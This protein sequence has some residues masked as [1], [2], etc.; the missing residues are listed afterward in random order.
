MTISSPSK[1]RK[2]L[3]LL[4][5]ILVALG[6]SACGSRS[7]MQASSWP[8]VSVADGTAYVAF[9][10]FVHAVDL[11]TG[12][13]IWTFPT[14]ADR[15]TTFYAPPA[16]SS[17]GETLVVGSYN[18]IIYA[19]NAGAPS[20]T[21]LWTFE[22]PEDRII[23]GPLIVED[24]VLVPTASGR[25]FAL[26]LEDGQPVWSEP[27]Q[28]EHA[29]WSAPIVQDDRVYV[30]GLDHFVY[31]ISLEDGRVNWKT[32]LGS[33]ISDS[34]T[35]TDG[36]LIS[37]N[38]AGT[39]AALDTQSG[40]VEWEFQADDSIWGSPAVHEGIAYFGDV[41]G[42]AHAIEVETGDELWRHVLSGPASASP[43]IFEDRVYFVTETGRMDALLLESGESAWPAS[44]EMVGRLLADPLL[45]PDGILVPAMESECL[46]YVV[47]PE[48]GAVRC[49][50]SAE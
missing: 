15:N 21:P 33:A 4:A 38:F 18:Q 35:L 27:F 19:L 9:G 11:E 25:L 28:A 5:L 8:G 3:I 10:Q 44:A 49:L 23:G 48:T 24:R 22:E 12:R 31:S 26:S 41:T 36:L 13:A 14:E 16:L 6:L 37:G 43:V 2:I 32:D 30:G 50:F 7:V 29:I 17:D 1:F 46:L 47:E 40:R 42:E 45:S 20:N 34:P 39:L